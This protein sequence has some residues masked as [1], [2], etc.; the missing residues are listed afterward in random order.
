MSEVN[1]PA[2][3]EPVR[4]QTRSWFSWVWLL[5]L[6]ALGIGLTML[7]RVWEQ[8]G[9]V[10]VIHFESA[11]GLSA[12]Q[13]EVKFR[14]VVIGEVT[15]ISLTDDNLGVQVKVQLE[16]GSDA[17]VSKDARY[18]IVQPRISSA[19]VS[20]LG[21]LLSGDY[22]AADPGSDR[23]TTDRFEGLDTPPPVTFGEQGRSFY[24][25]ADRLGSMNNGS[26]LYYRDIQVGQVVGYELNPEGTDV[27]IELFVQSPYDSRITSSSRFWAASGIDVQVGAD[28]LD[29]AVQSLM[30]LISGGIAFENIDQQGQPVEAD[31]EFRL[32]P[33]KGSALA[34]DRGHS[35]PVMMRFSQTLRGLDVGAPVEFMGRW[36]GEVTDVELDYDPET[37]SFPLLVY[38]NLYPK[39][40][41]DAYS[42]LRNTLPQEVAATEASR[43]LFDQF[44]GRGLSA[45]ARTGNLLTGKRFIALDF[46]EPAASD[47]EIAQDGILEIPTTLTS[48]D[49]IQD[50]L[51]K[52]MD[53]VS[54][55]P[56]ES[57]VENVNGSF[58]SLKSTLDTMDKQTLPEMT[59]ALASIEKVGDEMDRTM[60]AVRDILRSDS[61]RRGQ[62]Q[63]ALTEMERMAR[64]VRNLTDYLRRNP[65]SLLRGRSTTG[66]YE[67]PE[68]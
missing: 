14:N 31:R 53:R 58:R 28:G 39:T 42:K 27:S 17:F 45:E 21:T 18:W 41:G 56:I 51:A 4:S 38:A 15:D 65:E 61:P 40:M 60:E 34:P 24:V 29:V 48:L 10:I 30:A 9:P 46:Q 44:V 55:L 43:Q 52:L 54:G 12:G 23:Q 49:Q 13:T 62:L 68:Q 8:A 7:F 25:K 67:E 37:Q 3:Y 50:Q 63:Q 57:M 64:S 16:Q 22:I 59:K 33:D 6:V 32:Y 35:V 19:G 47:P 66:N 2:P 20:G 26:P 11:E 36:I 5:P 1:R